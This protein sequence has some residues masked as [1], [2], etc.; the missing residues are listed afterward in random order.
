MVSS[1]RN[2]N[3]NFTQVLSRAHQEHCQTKTFFSLSIGYD[4]TWD[5]YPSVWFEPSKAHNRK[6]VTL[7]RIVKIPS[8]GLERVGF[9]I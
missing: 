4:V 7:L 3:F 2:L 6:V 9:P 5:C 8:Y 1:H